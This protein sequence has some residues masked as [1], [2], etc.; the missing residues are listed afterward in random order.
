M[1]GWK[2]RLF[3]VLV[4][5]AALAV[6]ISSTFTAPTRTEAMPPFAQ[7]YGLKCS[8][9]HTMVPLLNAYGRYVQRTGY[10]SLDRH[11]LA[12]AIPLWIGES[13]NS[14]STAGAGSGTPR[15]S[16]GNL[17]LHAVGYASPDITYHAQQFI[18]A[19]DQSG[20]VDT[21]W[22]T[23][24]N[25]FHHE[26][27]LFVGK[28]LNPAPSAYGQNFE[29]D[30]PHASSTAVG[31][32]DWGATY[33]N[34]WGTRL[35]YVHSALDAEAGYYLT[36]FDLNG[37]TNFAPG[38][39]TFQWKLAYALPTK[40]Y[41]FGLFG[42]SGSIPVST[43][44]GLDRYHST[45]AFVQIDP[46]LNGRPGALAVYQAEFDDNPG[47][48]PSTLA[49]GPTHSRGA[50]FELYEPLL[51]GGVVV[52]LRHD[53]NDSGPGGLVTNGNALNLAFNVP[54][55]SYLHGYLEANIGANSALAGASNGPT[56]KSMLW[57]T[58]PIS[59]VK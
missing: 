28:I 26:G 18:T 29:L 19:A 32:H 2:L 3:P 45:A 50:S 6:L 36:A 15:N 22:V 51:R 7:A 43:N 49:L 16:F 38:D 24:N 27:H 21:L 44:S 13:L 11:V 40:P 39:K 5:T 10:A 34:R 8:A 48:G 41:E 4:A 46:G 42:S 23:Y 9:C 47:I 53:F 31:E 54:R 25:V 1:N 56:W 20:G 37:A 14:D 30:G 52:S 33:G 12:R 59:P 55:F 57:L 17:A 35:A 58:L